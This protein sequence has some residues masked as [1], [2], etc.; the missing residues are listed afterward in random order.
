[1]PLQQIHGWKFQTG[2]VLRAVINGQ[3]QQ[4]LAVQWI[5]RQ[6][7][8]WLLHV[9][10]LLL[11]P[12]IEVIKTFDLEDIKR[13]P[14]SS[15]PSRGRK[16]QNWNAY[17]PESRT[18][19]VPIGDRQASCALQQQFLDLSFQCHVFWP[20]DLFS[21]RLISSHRSFS[22]KLPI[23]SHCHR[24]LCHPISSHLNSRLLRFFTVI[25]SH[26]I[27][28]HLMPPLPF[29]GLL[30]WSQLFSSLLMSPELSSLLSTFELFSFQLFSASPFYAARLNSA[31]LSSSPLLSCQVI[32]S[33]LISAYLSFPQIWKIRFWSTLKWFLK[34]K[35]QAPKLRKSAAKSLSQPWCSHSNQPWRIH[36]SVICRDWLAKHKR[37]TRKNVRNCSSKTHF[38]GDFRQKLKVEDGK[39]KLSCENDSGRCENEAF[40]WDFPQENESWRCENTPFVRDF[41]QKVTVPDVKTKLSWE[42]SLKIWKSKMWKRGFRARHPSQNL[43]VEDVRPKLSVRDFRQ[44]VKVEEGCVW[45]FLPKSESRRCEN[46]A[47]VRDTPHKIW[48]WKMWDRSFRARLPSKSEG[49]RCENGGC[50]WD[51]LQKVKVENVKTKLSCETCLR[52]SEWKIW[53]CDRLW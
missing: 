40:V 29:P 1:M 41:L 4:W 15:R 9:Y 22:W 21:P 53:K 24:S 25:S 3:H 35:S 30:S 8:G 12:N 50:V 18:K 11:W 37:T 7:E 38:V 51:F 14:S 34:S 6:Q 5:S 42:T 20:L 17:S 26:L 16:F 39:T 13:Y 36:Y 19:T 31:L 46:E 10:L 28:S 45:D 52:N 49:W 27:S 23:A 32:P 43:K 48:K 44:K 47:F 33:G 2:P